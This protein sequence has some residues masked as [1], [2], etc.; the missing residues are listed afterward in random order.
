MAGAAGTSSPEV[1]GKLR[2]GINGVTSDFF[3]WTRCKGLRTCDVSLP[4]FRWPPLEESLHV[5]NLCH[6]L[7]DAASL[8]N[9][10]AMS[11]QSPKP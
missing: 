6:Q 2:V 7:C 5:E 8:Q 1:D 9:N 4:F 3:G 10:D 11:H